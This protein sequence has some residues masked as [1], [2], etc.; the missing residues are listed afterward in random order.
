MKVIHVRAVTAQQRGEK[1]RG[2]GATRRNGFDG[3][4]C[5]TPHP[6]PFHTSHR[7]P[8]TP[9]VRVCTVVVAVA[10]AGAMAADG[11][12]LGVEAGRRTRCKPSLTRHG[13]SYLQ[14]RL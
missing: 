7:L 1:Q 3:C 12:G 14:V 5:L 2:G 10:M 11:V 9:V 6:T 8:R 13:R 4:T